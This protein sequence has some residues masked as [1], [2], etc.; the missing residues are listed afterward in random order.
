MA[1][2]N[3]VVPPITNSGSCFDRPAKNSAAGTVRPSLPQPANLFRF[4]NGVTFVQRAAYGDSNREPDLRLGRF[5]RCWETGLRALGAERVNP[6]VTI[7]AGYYADS[8]PNL[9]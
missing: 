3:C 7:G 6:L 8:R 1:R 9:V 4:G 5:R 2:P